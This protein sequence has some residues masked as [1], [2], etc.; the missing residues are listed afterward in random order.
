MIF[1]FLPLLQLLTAKACTLETIPDD[2]LHSIFDRIPARHHP[3]FYSLTLASKTIRRRAFLYF[4]LRNQKP[5]VF[6]Q[7]SAL[8]SMLA[9]KTFTV[10]DFY[11]VLLGRVEYD[12][13]CRI[14]W[15]VQNFFRIK[16]STLRLPS[17]GDQ[18]KTAMLAAVL[19]GIA[20]P[21]YTLLN[22]WTVALS[23]IVL[24]LGTALIQKRRFTNLNRPIDHILLFERPSAV[25]LWQFI[26]LHFIRFLANYWLDSQTS[27]QEHMHAAFATFLVP[28]TV[29]SAKRQFLAFL[30]AL[31]IS[32]IFQ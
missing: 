31:L 23:L 22:T 12:E 17:V 5:D 20:L 1:S 30:I 24:I 3:S 21:E 18:C 32:K 19:S 7:I 29:V 28:W 2:L 25:L 27:H 13:L 9:T 10:W 6:T 11:E 26:I 16:Y 4:A 8:N 14:P 15:T